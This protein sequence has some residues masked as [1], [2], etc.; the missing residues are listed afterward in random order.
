MVTLCHQ[1]R[2]TITVIS[3]TVREAHLA[4]GDSLGRCER[5]SVNKVIQR[6]DILPETGGPAMLVPA[7]GLLLIIG[8]SIGLLV[9]RQQ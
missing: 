9:V 6:R 4:H 2:K 7:V 1:G 3:P 8:A 5:I